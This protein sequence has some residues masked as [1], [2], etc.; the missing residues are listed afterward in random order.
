MRQAQHKLADSKVA[1]STAEKLRKQLEAQLEH[2]QADKANLEAQRS[3]TQ[4]SHE[5]EL[6]SLRHTMQLISEQMRSAQTEFDSTLLTAAADLGSMKA[7]SEQKTEELARQLGQ[8]DFALRQLRAQLESATP[9]QAQTQDSTKQQKLEEQISNLTDELAVVK[10]QHESAVADHDSK[11]EHVLV[12]SNQLQEQA[13]S[14]QDQ[15]EAAKEQFEQSEAKAGRL[16]T[17]LQTKSKAADEKQTQLET[18][19]SELQ[20]QLKSQSSQSEANAVTDALEIEKQS[21]KAENDELQQ[22]VMDLKT[23]L[24]QS[25]QQVCLLTRYTTGFS[26]ASPASC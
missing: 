4:H 18:Q 8:S 15:L 11:H 9:A 13:I 10:T 12:Q 17:A 20:Q 16:K 14:L 21:S 26:A 3:E 6:Q 1:A 24:D 5:E 2:A 7:D 23:E 22:Q 19:L 25:R